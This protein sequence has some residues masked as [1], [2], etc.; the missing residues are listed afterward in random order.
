MALTSEQGDRCEE[1]LR[2][3]RSGSSGA[4]IPLVYS[5]FMRMW[6]FFALELVIFLSPFWLSPIVNYFPGSLASDMGPFVVCF[7]FIFV[8]Y[9]ITLVFKVLLG[10]QIAW[11]KRHWVDFEQFLAVQGRWDFAGRIAIISF[12]L[13]FVGMTTLG[14]YVFSIHA[15]SFLDSSPTNSPGTGRS[16][17]DGRGP[18][19]IN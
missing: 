17:G 4:F 6:I 7:L 18:I 14:I 13:L 3:I 12:A 5:G 11:K 2:V 1:Q 10:K 19:P 16:F 9:T 8:T 15:P